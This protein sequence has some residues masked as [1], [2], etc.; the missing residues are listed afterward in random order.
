MVQEYM[1]ITTRYHTDFPVNMELGLEL[2]KA[3][4][5]DSRVFAVAT[6]WLVVAIDSER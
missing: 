1:R 6:R 3:I 5:L 2:R 4:C